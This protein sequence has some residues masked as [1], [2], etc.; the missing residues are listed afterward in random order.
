LDG[1]RL[2]LVAGQAGVDGA[3]YRTEVESFTDVTYR[4]VSE[5]SFWEARAKDGMFYRYGVDFRSYAF[6]RETKALYSN[7]WPVAEE[8]NRSGVVTHYTHECRGRMSVLGGGSWCL[9]DPVLVSIEYGAR[10]G[11]AA[12]ASATHLHRVRIHYEPRTDEYSGNT[13]AYLAS[14]E[15]QERIASI[16]TEYANEVLRTVRLNYETLG[17]RGDMLTSVT[18]CVPTEYEEVCL[19]PTVFEYALQ[20]GSAFTQPG[21][22]QGISDVPRTFGGG[23]MEKNEGLRT[24]QRRSKPTI[25]LDVN[26]DGL[27]DFLGPQRVIS[28]Q[29]KDPDADDFDQWRVLLGTMGGQGDLFSGPHL[30]FNEPKMPSDDMQYVTPASVADIN[31]DGLSDIVEGRPKDGGNVRVWMA[32]GNPGEMFVAQDFPL[33][34][35]VN[36]VLFPMDANGDGIPDIVG[37]AGADKIWLMGPGAQVTQTIQIPQVPAGGHWS[38]S[39]HDSGAPNYP[40]PLIFDVD[41]DGAPNLL[42]RTDHAATRALIIEAGVGGAPPIASWQYTELDAHASAGRSGGGGSMRVLDFN[43][44]GLHDVLEHGAFVANGEGSV[45]TRGPPGEI[46]LTGSLWLNNGAYAFSKLRAYLPDVEAGLLDVPLPVE[47]GTGVSPDFFEISRV[48]DYD[49]DG[50]D[51][52]ISL[53][54]TPSGREWYTLRD[55]YTTTRS[56]LPILTAELVDNLPT[57]E[58]WVEDGMNPVFM[59]FDA[60]GALDALFFEGGSFWLQRGAAPARSML[61]AV[62]DGLGNHVEITYD[63][64]GDAYTPAVSCDGETRCLPKAG[65]VVSGIATF[66][67]NGAPEGTTTITYADARIGLHG[68]GALGFRSRTVTD[69]A[70]DGSWIRSVSEQYENGQTYDSNSMSYPFAGRLLSSTTLT[71]AVRSGVTAGPFVGVA[72]MTSFKTVVTNSYALRLSDQYRPFVV[73]RQSITKRL[74]LYEGEKLLST[75]TVS[76]EDDGA[77]SFDQYGNS[78]FQHTTQGGP[79]GSPSHEVTVRNWFY[80]PG[81]RNNQTAPDPSLWEVGLISAREVESEGKKRLKWFAYETDTGQLETTTRSSDSGTV[82]TILLRDEVGN[83]THARTESASE[84]KETQLSYDPLG[85]RLTGVTGPTGIEAF[86]QLDSATG[87]VL[88]E[89]GPNGI[90]TQ[91]VY[92]GFGRQMR[93]ITPT[94]QVTTSLLFST[95]SLSAYQVFRLSRDGAGAEATSAV[96]EAHYDSRG[97]VHVSRS[98][99]LGGTII[100]QHRFYNAA[101]LLEQEELPH[102]VGAPPSAIQLKSYE[103]DE[104]GSLRRITTPGDDGEPE[105]VEH[106]QYGT[107]YTTQPAFLPQTPAELS[108]TVFVARKF[109][110]DGIP[111]TTYSGPIQEAVMRR[112]GDGTD[113]EETT[114]TYGAFG[115]VSA[116]AGASN[117]LSIDRDDWG[118][119]LS[120]SDSDLGTVNYTYDAFDR[121]STMV[122][123]DGRLSSYHYDQLDRLE[124]AMHPDAEERFVYDRD[125]EAEGGGEPP[126]ENSLGRLVRSVRETP[127]GTYTQQFRYESKPASGDPLN[128]RAL[129]ERVKL[130]TPDDEFESSYEY[131]PSSSRVL[132]QHYP[133]TE[134]AL[135]FGVRYCYDDVG[136]VTHVFN[137]QAPIDCAS[138]EAGPAPYWKRTSIKDGLAED[139]YQ[140]GNGVA[141]DLD[142]DPSTYRLSGHTIT[143]TNTTVGFNYDYEPGGRLE[144]ET[145]SGG[146]N[147]ARDYA[148]SASGL[149]NSVEQGENGQ[150]PSPTYLSNYNE[151]FQLTSGPMDLGTFS[152]EGAE[153]S[154]VGNRLKEVTDPLDPEQ[155]VATFQYDGRG[156]QILREG[157]AIT[158]GYQAIEYNDFNLPDSITTG[159]GSDAFTVAFDYTAA[160]QRAHTLRSTSEIWHFAEI[161][162]Q[163]ERQNDPDVA[164]EHRYWVFAQGKRIAQITRTQHPLDGVWSESTDYLHYDR[165]GSVIATSD[166]AGS[167]TEQMDYGVYGEPQDELPTVFGYTGYRHEQ[168]LGLADARGRFYDPKF[169]VFLSAD[170]ASTLSGGSPRMNRYAYVGY[171]P[172]NFVDPSGY[173]PLS[174]LTIW[175]NTSHACDVFTANAEALWS[176]IDWETAATFGGGVLAGAVCGAL[177]TPLGPAAAAAAA[178]ACAGAV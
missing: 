165:L 106:Y 172:V 90:A 117:T 102:P 94:G 53:V 146:V 169:G 177:A 45:S 131:V 145:R 113:K 171:D 149:L 150:P 119:V 122:D 112:R 7:I 13:P 174:V 96:S 34:A 78:W 64:S 176:V 27:P 20:E 173:C 93:V 100:E 79:P 136:S 42:V 138:P 175:G 116:Y 43:G 123:A 16:S 126:T 147:V 86:V 115:Q 2:I 51:D 155:T 141:V 46:L 60:D 124:L 108:R 76:Y 170:P 31:L 135:P 35:G 61:K 71:A 66:D 87:R 139:G 15:L 28:K 56:M 40:S 164:Q 166:S 84:I 54:N 168:D 36:T 4:E 162:E 107:R 59:D 130:Q 8:I 110:G 18:E 44:D 104:L 163:E 132:V 3:R 49:G 88:T 109:D 30:V 81:Q 95:E 178:G 83:V 125:L 148:Y 160:G 85:L 55:K 134:A 32:T 9:S 97:R 74:Q 50:R 167:V 62:T 154:P 161:Y 151:S 38:C 82:D 103:Y 29:V 48:L 80:P 144:A 152:Y 11:G 127:T 121:L 133:E 22:E 10:P 98:T 140:L 39:W 47:T 68:R 99:G 92:D 158:G 26:G 14:Q 129:L 118:R 41:G 159:T 143:A 137:A 72:P 77:L 37:C 91:Y 89:V 73:P 156:N 57:A 101:G 19:P 65:V 1:Q 63:T 105:V 120:V 25:V 17:G 33:N 5:E 58:R 52:I 69:F 157:P 6:K 111:T 23:P 75:G 67:G 70:P 142:L 114:I 128:N 24:Q 12:T 21:W 153:S